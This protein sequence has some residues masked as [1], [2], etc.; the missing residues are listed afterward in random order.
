MTALPVTVA[1]SVRSGHILFRV[2]GV[3]FV[4]GY[5]D[6][7]HRIRDSVNGRRPGESIPVVLQRDPTNPHDA[8]AVEVHVPAVGRIG[9]VPAHIAADLA[10]SLEAG[11][12]WHAHVE[13]VFVDDD[14]P[15]RPGV[16]VELRRAD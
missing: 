14:H 6:N 10:P 1:G 16:S 13:G 9:S 4:A 5:P 15:D 2:V 7:V 3:S 11:H 12:R 8:N